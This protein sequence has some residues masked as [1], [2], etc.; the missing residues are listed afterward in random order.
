[1]EELIELIK[2]SG[3]TITVNRNQIL[4]T[5]ESIDTNL[6]Y[7]V[8]GSLRVFALDGEEEQI[9]RFGYKEN[10]IVSL[11]SFFT[12]KPSNL[13]IQA[14]KKTVIKVIPKTQIDILINT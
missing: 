1:M 2:L 3:N 4:K 13:F 11:D 14:L 10:L 8:S 7:V 9:I 12:G 5:K 6:Y